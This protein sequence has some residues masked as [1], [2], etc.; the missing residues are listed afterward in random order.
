MRKLTQEEWIKKAINVHGNKYD[1][2]KVEYV[3]SRT[4]VCIICPEHGEFWQEANG[5]LMG[6]GCKKCYGNE[7]MTTEGFIEKAKKIHG[8][9]YDYS[10]VEYTSDNKTKICIICKKHGEFWQ[11]PNSHLSG[12]GCPVCRYESNKKKLRKSKEEF[13]KEAK[14]I[15]GDK[16]DYSKV[17]YVD[18]KTK[19][20]IVC[21]EHGE[22]WQKPNNHLN[23]NGCYECGRK[24]MG[25]KQTKNT[26]LFIEESN[27]IHNNKYDYSK[28]KYIG[29]YD[30]VC[31]I[32]PE[33]GEF[34]QRPSSHLNGQGCPICK[35]S[36]LENEIRSILIENKIDFIQKATKDVI[37]W[38]GDQHLDF[39]LPDKKIAI[40]CQGK[41]HFEE[42][43]F[44]GGMD[45]FRKQIERDVKKRIKCEENEVNL[46]YYAKEDFN[47]IYKVITDKNV[48]VSTIK[49][50]EKL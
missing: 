39:Y 41:Q 16:Y 42:S 20:C 50:N 25:E 31:I 48:L 37:P 15:H 46:I 40:E 33:H 23:G 2:S 49:K 13:I 43:D 44:F 22:F 14:K 47:P 36:K 34:W 10:N 18:N 32:C 17:E 1:Y 24:M 45:G 27:K 4:K 7:K 38:I 29:C 11:T 21:L 12:N 9:K 3:N 30:K 26:A 28:V 19:V 35:E 5:H 6:Q 8:D